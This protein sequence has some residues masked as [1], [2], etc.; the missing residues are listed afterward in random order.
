MKTIELLKN[1]RLLVLLFA[2]F[3]IASCSDDDEVPEE[4]DD[5]EVITDVNLIF[6]NN[7]DP[8]DVVMASAQ[9]SDGIGSMSLE[10]VNA[11]VLATDTQYT[12]TF[13]ILNALDS[14]DTEDI[15]EEIQEED[16][17]HQF[18]FSFTED[19]FD[20]PLGDGNID[21]ASDPINYNGRDEN[22][23]PVGLSTNWTTPIETTSGGTFR[24]LLKHQPGIKS[25]TTGS[26]DG[27]TDIDVTFT[28]NIQ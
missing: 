21:S 11:I 13:E 10:V 4:E 17:D 3:T 26:T 12:M 7:A 6:T 24:V 5:V 19:A 8:N 9:D 25:D 18:F 16:N 1:F 28:L 22:G 23:N 14:D 15:T 20:S 27:D 2:G